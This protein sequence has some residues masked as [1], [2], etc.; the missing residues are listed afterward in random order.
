MIKLTNVSKGF[1]ENAVFKNLDF[2]FEDHRTYLI[3]GP[4]G[5]GKTTLLN[6]IAGYTSYTGK[7]TLYTG[8]EKQRLFLLKNFFINIQTNVR[9]TRTRWR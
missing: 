6:M 8:I 3:S 2:E 7:Y 5:L 9:S 4:S 1:G